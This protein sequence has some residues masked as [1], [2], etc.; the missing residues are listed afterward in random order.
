M[1]PLTTAVKNVNL[2]LSTHVCEQQENNFQQG[3]KQFRASELPLKQVQ[4]QS[5][6]AGKNF[7]QPHS[8]GG[9]P[10]VF[11]DNLDDNV[12]LVRAGK[13]NSEQLL[14]NDIFKNELDEN[15]FKNHLE[16]DFVDPAGYSLSYAKSN[17]FFDN[18]NKSFDFA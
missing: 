15:I 12:L 16:L 3:L 8:T 4:K 14:N 10:N 1:S 6:T 11:S 9:K 7:E 17:N 5:Q 18:H 13:K 2:D